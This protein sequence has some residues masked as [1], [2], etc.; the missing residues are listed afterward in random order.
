MG[1]PP[2]EKREKGGG[3]PEA[4]RPPP[5]GSASAELVEQREHE[6]REVVRVSVG[7]A[8]LVGHGVEHVVP[9]L[10]V[11]DQHEVLENLHG[12]GTLQHGA[13]LQF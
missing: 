5:A 7:E 11:Q 2:R 8:Q 6:A 12:R 10:C 9:T 1:G 13:V 4:K 3:S